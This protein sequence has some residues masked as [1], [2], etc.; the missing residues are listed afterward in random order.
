MLARGVLT[1]LATRIYF[2]DEPSNADDPVLGLVPAHRR[3]TLIARRADASRYVL[4]I[5]LQGP[6]ETVFFDV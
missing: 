1:R 4:D 6:G 2:E 3:G 5:L